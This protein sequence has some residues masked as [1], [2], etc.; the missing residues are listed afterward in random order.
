VF[1]HMK[2]LLGYFDAKL[3]RDG[4]CNP[5]VENDSLHQNSN[6]KGVKVTTLP[7]QKCSC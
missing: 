6:D 1:D 7:Q 4:I 2:I 5:T 3:G